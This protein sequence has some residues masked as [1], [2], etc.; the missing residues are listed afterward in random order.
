MRTSRL[1]T[2]WYSLHHKPHHLTSS[3]SPLSH[4]FSA[5]SASSTGKPVSLP[6]CLPDGMFLRAW[7]CHPH[8]LHLCLFCHIS[9]HTIKNSRSIV[10][11]WQ[12]ENMFLPPC[13]KS[14]GHSVFLH[15]T[16]APPDIENIQ[17]GWWVEVYECCLFCY[18]DITVDSTDKAQNLDLKPIFL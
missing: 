12:H 3:R 1:S 13:L 15:N 4:A 11:S 5:E 16:P 17:F 2:K 18:Q 10:G 14:T 9:P 7:L 6:V 8:L